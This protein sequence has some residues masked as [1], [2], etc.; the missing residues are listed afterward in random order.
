MA[1]VLFCIVYWPQK[2]LASV[3]KFVVLIGKIWLIISESGSSSFIMAS[4]VLQLF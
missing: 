1:T 4:Q 2:L 3:P